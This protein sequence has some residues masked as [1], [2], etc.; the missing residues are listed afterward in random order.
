MSTKGE[1]DMRKKAIK[2][3]MGLFV[4]M[5]FGLTGCGGGGSSDSS[6]SAQRTTPIDGYWQNSAKT[7]S[8]NNGSVTDTT[9]MGTS[10]TDKYG[11]YSISGN[12]VTCNFTSY[13]MYNTATLPSN[14]ANYHPAPSINISETVSYTFAVSGNTLTLV[15]GNGTTVFTK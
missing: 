12:V 4:A 10:Y 13:N 9:N 8:F 2:V 6:A 15:G 11:A 5:V 3:M 1:Q 14:P 7:I